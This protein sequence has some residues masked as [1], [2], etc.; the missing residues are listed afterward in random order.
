MRFQHLAGI[1]VLV[2]ISGC[3]PGNPPEGVHATTAKADTLVATIA[4][5]AK[6]PKDWQGDWLG[7]EGTR[8]TLRATGKKVQ[9][10]FLTPDGPRQ[11]Y[12]EW[13]GNHIVFSRSQA[14]ETIRRGD[15]KATGMQ[16]LS[17]KKN[18]LVISS[19]EG[20]CRD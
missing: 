9:V 1:A 20:Y 12:G 7:T 5:K 10:D 2:W 17:E 18:C 4:A 15:G 3:K 14:P 6:M 8:M 11:F 13:Q 19:G 16:G